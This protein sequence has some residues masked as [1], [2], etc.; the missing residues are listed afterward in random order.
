MSHPCVVEPGVSHT[1]TPMQV[2]SKNKASMHGAVGQ[3]LLVNV[4]ELTHG[5]GAQNHVEWKI[6]E[7]RKSSLSQSTRGPAQSQTRTTTVPIML[8]YAPACSFLGK[9]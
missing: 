3:G 5:H 4:R 6:T 8:H 7:T 2:W 9:I 1:M